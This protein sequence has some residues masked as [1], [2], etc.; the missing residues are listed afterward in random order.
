MPKIMRVWIVLLCGSC[1]L[2]RPVRSQEA[3]SGTGEGK[4]V[5]T[6]VETM[7]DFGQIYEEDEFATHIFRLRNTGTAPLVITH[8]QSSCGCT[9]PQWTREPVA[10][11]AEGEIVITYSAKNRVGPFRKN[12]TVHTNDTEQRL[13]LT[14]A[15]EVISAPPDLEN[16]FRDT[17][18]TVQTAQTA[19][20]FHTVRPG[21][22]VKQ[23][24]WIRN[25][26]ESDVTLAFENVPGYLGIEIPSVL[27]SGKAERIKMTFDA[28]KL[29]EKRGRFLDKLTWKATDASGATVTRILPLSMNLVDD[30]SAMST[31]E[32]GNAPA[33]RFS[34]NALNFG[35][36][37]KKS[38]FLGLGNRQVSQQLTITNAGKTPLTLH[39]V[40]CDDQR[41]RI[42]GLNKKTL[43]ADESLVLTV[44]LQ[45]KTL[46]GSLV[47]DI[48]VVCNDPQGPV[49]EVNVVAER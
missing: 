37:K 49:R 2:C 31:E 1:F 15:G 4:P 32:K 12:V 46:D 43:Q 34:T 9:E 45:P 14:I 30:F 19:F 11:G 40:G 42:A 13:R 33:I 29:A 35:K 26:A 24:V 18:G 23:D 3:K 5:A 25:I 44:T 17:I 7:F 20:M 6:L 38:G 8:V 39:S 16:V 48:Y 41:V 36:L 21:D 47:K 27:K 10:P 22:I 28:N